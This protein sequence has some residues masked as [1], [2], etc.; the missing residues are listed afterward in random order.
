MKSKNALID[1]LINPDCLKEFSLDDFDTFIKQSYST[2]LVARVFHILTTNNLCSHV[3]KNLQWHFSSA[4]KV[5]LA[6]KF[7]VK[8]EVARIV[9]ALKYVKVEPVFLKGTAYILANDSCHQGRLFAD[10]DIF[11][12]KKDITST[13]EILRWNGWVANK[14]D[15]HDEKY[16]RDWMHEI[17]PMVNSKTNMTIDVHHNLIPLVSRIKLDSAKLKDRIES[18]KNDVKYLA[19]EDRVLHSAAHLLLD[20]EFEHGF[21]DVHDLYL[22][23]SERA[24]Q[25]GF[26]LILYYCLMLQQRIFTLVIPDN[27]I[28][29]L[30]AKIGSPVITS[31][32]LDMFVTVIHPDTALKNS[33]KQR[34]YAQ[35]LFIRSHW[36]K[37]PMYILIPHLFHKAF[38]TPYIEWKKNKDL[39]SKIVK[40]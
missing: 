32:V 11:V 37:M 8:N 26:E 30:A 10:I 18:N 12:D 24:E 15:E 34:I 19:P 27:Y 25:L 35:M 40:D 28:V 13:E 33:G 21:R 31:I 2:G 29:S 38:I 7:D 39:L 36:L 1:F 17:P 6:H 20:G 16:Y 22:L 3:P 5:F 23:I 9:A 14:L 4:H